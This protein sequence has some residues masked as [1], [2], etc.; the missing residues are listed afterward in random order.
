MVE[1]HRSSRNRIETQ[2]VHRKWLLP[3][4]GSATLRDRPVQPA[5][6]TVQLLDLIS[7]HFLGLGGHSDQA[8]SKKHP[9]KNSHKPLFAGK[10]RKSRSGYACTVAAFYWYSCPN[11]PRLASVSQSVLGDGDTTL[12]SLRTKM[13]RRALRHPSSQEQQNYPW[14][15]AEVPN[16]DFFHLG[17]ILI[18]FQTR[19]ARIRAPVVQARAAALG[20][21]VQKTHPLQHPCPRT[22]SAP[23]CRSLDRNP[24]TATHF[25]NSD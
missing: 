10:E 5:P 24:Y 13:V 8:H 3:V 21:P 9:E 15:N 17:Q 22:T 14:N 23:L 4:S 2:R 18:G 12:A 16:K 25:V 1:Y 7:H 20:V 19:V 11:T 6:S